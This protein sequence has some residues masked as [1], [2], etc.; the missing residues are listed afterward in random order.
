MSGKWV[1]Q[2]RLDI[3][4]LVEL[5]DDMR[6]SIAATAR[7]L[8]RF[9][10]EMEAFFEDFCDQ[11]LDWCLRVAGF[12]PAELG[13]GDRLFG[14]PFSRD[15]EE[16]R[17]QLQ[18]FEALSAGAVDTSSLIVTAVSSLLSGTETLDSA[19]GEASWRPRD[20]AQRAVVLISSADY[21]AGVSIDS[22]GRVVVSPAWVR[23]AG[24]RPS[25]RD[26]AAL[27][28]LSLQ[29]DSPL[30]SAVALDLGAWRD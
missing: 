23:A 3:V 22:E 5:S 18:H 20:E 13:A 2:A 25:N 11:S 9:I 4:L 21:P 19:A 17:R 14:H 27:L 29:Q 30:G 16:V 28:A 7:T 10:D 26:N 8:G 6:A 24:I 15:V 12:G 1:G